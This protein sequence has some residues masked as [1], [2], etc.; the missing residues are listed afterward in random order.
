[1]SELYL[2][3]AQSRLGK[4]VSPYE[5]KLSGALAEIFSQGTHHLTGVIVGLNNLGLNAPDGAPW[6]EPRFLAEM[7]R[8]G[9]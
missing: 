5:K 1:M 3:P 8:L 4:P 6:D 9:E 2:D 7:R